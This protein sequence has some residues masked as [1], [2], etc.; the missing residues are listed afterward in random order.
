MENV[1][2]QIV[3][4]HATLG[5]R[6]TLFTQQLAVQFVPYNAALR[7]FLR[8]HSLAKSIHELRLD[9][10]AFKCADTAHYA[11][12]CRGLLD[13]NN[14]RTVYEMTMPGEG[15]RIAAA[16]LQTPL[17]AHALD[18]L[19]HPD[20]S[21][22]QLIEIIEPRPER[23]GKD[24][25]GIDHSEV[26]VDT[27][28]DLHLWSNRLQALSI[29]WMLESNPKHDWLSVPLDARGWELELTNVPFMHIIRDALLADHAT[30]L[31][32]R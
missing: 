26:L 17:A 31:K 20:M 30:T 24:A 12:I 3:K 25:V 22:C 13:D 8:R 10:I 14:V 29:D 19:W 4:S 11:S 32:D 9:H 5:S 18:P 2:N 27:A 28:L 21:Q 23:V 15:R 16:A 1:Q 6:R 7:A